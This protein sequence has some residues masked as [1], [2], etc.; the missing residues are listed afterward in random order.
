MTAM[1]AG[2]KLP[3]TASNGNLGNYPNLGM[4]MRFS[5]HVKDLESP[6]GLPS[7]GDL[8]LWQSCKNLQMELQYKK[9]TQGMSLVDHW[10]PEKISYSPVTLERPMERGSSERV[11]QWLERYVREWRI[12]PRTAKGRPPYTAVVITLL[13]Y[14]LNAVM[15]WTLNEARPSKW[16]GPSLSASDSKV[17]IESLV[18]DHSGFLSESSGDKQPI[19][20]TLSVDTE[21]GEYKEIIS[22]NVTFNFNPK[23][24]T[25][26]HNSKT[27]SMGTQ[28]YSNLTDLGVPSLSLHG[29][30]FD[31]P[32]TL[33]SCE[34][35]LDWSYPKRRTGNNKSVKPLLPN[36][37]FRWGKF[38]VR[39]VRA[40]P[41]IRVTLSKV[42]IT[43][44]RFDVDGKPTRASVS[45]DLEPVESTVKK[46]QNPTS[47]GLPG[48]GGHLMAAG[49]TLH[50]IAL[51][52]YGDPADWRPL[53]SA[54]QIDDPLRMRPGSALYLPD[55]SELQD[56][57]AP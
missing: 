35:L 15:T 44:E 56:L 57:G 31:G 3:N 7:E 41:K 26:T 28:I 46:Q 22:K 32:N 12:Y 30:I 23:S 55:H 8:G 24:L 51:D 39:T 36:L 27:S 37:I 50:G 53:A 21:D 43:Y 49:D 20:A 5:V 42:D 11:R 33:N 6:P 52:R 25:I 47:G 10:L 16:I 34:A 54:N 38:A 14:Q 18:I 45:L 1:S 2:Q 17:A 19:H 48:R 9:F 13:D 4:S 29:L 40:D